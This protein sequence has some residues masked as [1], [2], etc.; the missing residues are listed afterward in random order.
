MSSSSFPAGPFDA[1]IQAW[2]DS[3]IAPV[4]IDL[5]PFPRALIDEQ[6]NPF[7]D[8]TPF[9]FET[10]T[11]APFHCEGYLMLCTLRH[12]GHTLVVHGPDSGLAAHMQDSLMDPK[13]ALEW[14]GKV[15]SNP[16]YDSDVPVINPD[17]VFHH[18][19]IKG[20]LCLQNP[21]SAPPPPS[22]H[23]RLY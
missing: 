11:G 3:G 23:R 15:F 8:G 17:G 22:R 2:V 21:E 7:P 1:Q 12:G 20:C 13:L 9:F 14:V 4:V 6:D 16:S 10:G 19:F 18:P 5:D